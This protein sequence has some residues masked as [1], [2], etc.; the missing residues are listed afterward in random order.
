MYKLLTNGQE[1]AARSDTQLI[2]PIVRFT[3]GSHNERNLI[4]TDNH[5]FINIAI[6]G[7]SGVGKS[8][9]AK[10]LASELGYV[11]IDT[12]AMFRTLAVYF[13]DLGIDAADR[14]K[15]VAALDHIEI[16][17][18]YIDGVQHMF[19]NGQDVTDRLRTEAVSSMASVTSQYGEVRGKLLEMQR[20]L[21]SKEN[22]IM[23]G[24]DI[25]TVVLP[26]A[27][28]KV[29]LTASA[30]VR[31]KRRYDQLQAAGKL[32]GATFEDILR[33]QEERDYRD[34]HREIA[35]LKPADDA[36]VID[37]SDMTKEEVR[38]AV[39]EVLHECKAC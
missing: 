4:M 1:C 32:E 9:I 11:Y 19:A 2:Y 21:A 17:I 8:T 31:A 20:E 16:G 14:E 29:F 10:L 28:V 7:P 26:D 12:G 13:T 22:V 38:N 39:L 35:P 25:G 30:K 34:T 37:T 5:T 18:S 33:D 27:Q 15:I 23:D 3:A 36:R 24:R 6:D